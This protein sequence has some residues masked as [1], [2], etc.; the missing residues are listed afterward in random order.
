VEEKT[1]CA[2]ECDCSGSTA[3]TSRSGAATNTRSSRRPPSPRSTMPSTPS[4]LSSRAQT[5]DSLRRSARQCN[6]VSVHSERNRPEA[7]SNEMI[8]VHVYCSS[9][10]PR[11]SYAARRLQVSSEQQVGT[12]PLLLQLFHAKVCVAVTL[13]T[14]IGWEMG[15]QELLGQA[16]TWHD[17]ATSAIA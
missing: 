13:S 4:A 10:M 5:T 11:L 6:V 17:L 2:D 15:T 8:T 7:A 3:S 1:R 12:V 9:P 14:L 16:A